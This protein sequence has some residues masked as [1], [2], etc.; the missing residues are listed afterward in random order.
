MKI[1]KENIGAAMVAMGFVGIFTS[2]AVGAYAGSKINTDYC[3][4]KPIIHSD[5]ENK[6][7]YSH[8]KNLEDK[9]ACGAAASVATFIIGGLLVTPPVPPR[10]YYVPPRSYYLSR[11]RKRN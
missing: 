11:R 5:I 7:Y 8:F 9:A 2:F 6:N 4:E 3:S 1:T 10:P